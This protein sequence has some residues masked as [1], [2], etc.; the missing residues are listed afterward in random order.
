[1]SE[2]A[3]ARLA[4]FLFLWLIVTGAGGQFA[5]SRL[6]PSSHLYRVALLSELVE[7][8]S[9]LVL[10]FALYAILRGVDQ[11]LAQLAMYFRIAESFLGCVGMIFGYARLRLRTTPGSSQALVDLTKYAGTAT[12]HIGVLCFS[13]GSILFFYVFTK[14]TWLPK[15]LSLL[16]I[17]ASVIVTLMALGNL[18]APEYG[19]TLNWGWLPIAAAEVLTGF[20]LMLART[21]AESE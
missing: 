5:A 17:I 14:S 2:R 12:F 1:M 15:W 18:L 16:G 19:S 20:W 4:G 13:L 9:A 3:W 10:A 8:V 6:A 7:T 11:L 21:P